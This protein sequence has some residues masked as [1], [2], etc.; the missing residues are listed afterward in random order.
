[1]LCCCSVRFRRNAR[2][3]K[4]SRA[5]QLRFRR[6][7]TDPHQHTASMFAAV[8]F[9]PTEVVVLH[10]KLIRVAAELFKPVQ[11]SRRPKC[12]HSV[13]PAP[14]RHCHAVQPSPEPAP[15]SDCPQVPALSAVQ[16]AAASPSCFR[17]SSCHVPATSC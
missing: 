13:S 8:L 16:L 17:N 4:W 14:P 9:K 12:D 15:S 1:M 2:W 7:R 11:P 5:V 3:E 6:V 10:D